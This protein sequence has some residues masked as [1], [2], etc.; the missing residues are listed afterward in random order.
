MKDTIKHTLNDT[1]KDTEKRNLSI[2]DSI[3]NSNPLSILGISESRA[4]EKAKSLSS[5]E[6]LNKN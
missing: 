2:F 5:R 4:S 6:C 1:I 3:L